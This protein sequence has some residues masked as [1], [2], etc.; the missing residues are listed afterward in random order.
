MIDTYLVPQKTVVAE[1]GD[2]P[3]VRVD[4]AANRVF[5]L[6]LNITDIIEQE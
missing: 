1:K 5:L 6:T 2:G 4:G 3:A